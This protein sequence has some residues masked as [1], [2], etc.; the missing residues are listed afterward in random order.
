MVCAQ[1]GVWK[2]L[3]RPVAPSTGQWHPQAPVAMCP[4]VL[5]TCC[6]ASADSAEWP[7]RGLR[8]GTLGC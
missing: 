1:F 8:S 2:S 7:A 6:P 5:G 4:V 3:D